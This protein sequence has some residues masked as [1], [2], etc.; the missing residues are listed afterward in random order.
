VEG[1]QL[2][3][4]GALPLK[5]L[6]SYAGL[7]ASAF[8]I[9]FGA[10]QFLS[11]IEVSANRETL[12]NLQD[13][14]LQAVSRILSLADAEKTSL[15]IVGSAKS[16]SDLS[17]AQS[18]LASTTDDE[19][20]KKALLAQARENLRA[21]VIQAPANPYAWLRLALISK[22]L[23]APDSDAYKYWQMSVMT[24]P[25]EDKI[26]TPRITL[27]VDLWPLLNNADRKAAFADIRNLYAHDHGWQIANEASPFMVNVIRAALVTDMVRFKEYDAFEKVRQL[28]PQGPQASAPKQ[29]LQ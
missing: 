10:R 7:T 5:N 29:G 23:G 17:L 1:K 6:I 12:E 27:A 19:I 4:R 20:E 11:D 15:S 3:V 13:G 8:L 21:S 2:E 9:F 24:G 22:A 14:K 25:N 28:R 18:S 16:F 26:L